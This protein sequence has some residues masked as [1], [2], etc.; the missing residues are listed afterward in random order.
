MLDFL[1]KAAQKPI[2]EFVQKELRPVNR[3]F[4]GGFSQMGADH[5]A[6]DTRTA[7]ELVQTIDYY[8]ERIPELQQFA[9]EIK[10]LSPKHMG[11]IADTLE[12]SSYHAMLTEN[13][14][15]LDRAF[16]Q[17]VK[18]KLVSQMIQASKENPEAMEL[19]EAIINNT[20]SIT[21]KYALYS[22]SGGILNMKEFAQHMKESA[23]VIGVIADETLKGG[24][25]M[26]FSKQERF[27]DF[28]KQFIN[29]ATISDKISFLFDEFIK[30]TD[31]ING[32]FNIDVPKFLRSTTPLAKVRENLAILPELVKNGLKPEQMDIVEFTTKNVN[33]V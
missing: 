16:S 9:K 3:L 1:K 15:N 32:V 2:Q 21:S 26:D 19:I 4:T 18:E 20:D 14:A 29:Q 11:L 17:V 10:T 28:I 31:S 7:E 12:L 5:R 6:P 8:V 30:L 25:T 13:E 23:K 27:M 33:L 22:M 24:Y